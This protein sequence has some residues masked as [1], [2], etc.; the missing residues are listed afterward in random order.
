LAPVTHGTWYE[1]D[2][3]TSVLLYVIKLHVT[4]INIANR[5]FDNVAKLKYLR[6]TLRDQNCMTEE[7]KSRC[8]S[9]DLG[10][11]L[12]QNLFSPHLLAKNIG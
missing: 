5:P 9:G 1:T 11:H 3:D 2:Y 12:V 7:I 10:Y 4:N 8:N 6:T